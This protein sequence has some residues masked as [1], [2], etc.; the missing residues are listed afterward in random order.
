MS[1]S[2]IITFAAFR[3][4]RQIISSKVKFIYR[5]LLESV[6]STDF[7]DTL[8]AVA[9]TQFKGRGRTPGYQWLSPPG[10]LLFTFAVELPIGSPF[11]KHLNALEHFVAVCIVETLSSINPRYGVC[12][13]FFNN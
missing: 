12:S 8:L 2:K 13:Y 4:D 6:S 5:E 10:A 3:K 1:I 11:E 9:G 7:K